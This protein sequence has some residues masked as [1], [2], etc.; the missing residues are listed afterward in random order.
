MVLNTKPVS[1]FYPATQLLI[2]TSHEVKKTQ[3][4]E[5]EVYVDM[6]T[7]RVRLWSGLRFLQ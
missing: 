2:V 1:F 3:F 4:Y 6:P 5:N 7:L